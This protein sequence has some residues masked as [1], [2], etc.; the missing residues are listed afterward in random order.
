VTSG[1]LPSGLSLNPA[2][3][4]ISGIPGANTNGA[5]T[6]TVT[7]TDSAPIP[8]TGTSTFVVT[9]AQGLFLS[10]TTPTVSTFATANAGVSTVTA[11]GGV[12]TYLY[13]IAITGHTL[14][15]GMTI[16]PF[17]G[18]IS[19]TITTPAGSY[20]VKV[21]ASDSTSGTP[22]TGSI[23][24]TVV[25]KLRLVATTPTAFSVGGS[26]APGV[27]NTMTTTGGSGTYTYALDVASQAFVNANSA[28]L[29][30]DTSTGVLTVGAGY[31]QTSAFTVTV[32]ATDSTTPVNA[33]AAPTGSTTFSFVIG[34]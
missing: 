1:L 13:S 5:Y 14:P 25:V 22:L 24:F 23:T 9:I 8:V 28:W 32:T 16:N 20:L 12:S 6:V 3:G 21:S 2:T 33:S 26:T 31:V 10:N 30:F 17:T 7:A 11:S 4:Q 29:S 27:F 34:A 19:T 18:V 15:A